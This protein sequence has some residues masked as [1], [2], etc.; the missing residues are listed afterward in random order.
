[1]ILSSK[2]RLKTNKLQK[3][4]LWKSTEIARF[5]CNWILNKQQENYTNGNKFIKDNELRKELTQ[6]KKS[7]LFWL[8]EVSNKRN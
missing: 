4:Q 1:M 3:S 6:L 7:E 2:V 8:N 5:I